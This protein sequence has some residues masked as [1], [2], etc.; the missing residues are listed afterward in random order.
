MVLRHSEP[1]ETGIM[2]SMGP[3]ATP[4]EHVVVSDPLD[5]VF[6]FEDPLSGPGLSDAP[7]RTPTAQHHPSDFV[8]LQQQHVTAGYRDGVTAAKAESVQAGFDEGFSLGAAIGVKAGELI[9][10]LEGVVR[11]LPG[12]LELS[13]LLADAKKELDIRSVFAPEYWAADGTWTYDVQAAEGDEVVFSDVAAAHPLI[14][15]WAEIV[16]AEMRKWSIDRAVLSIGD[17][18]R[19]G[20]AP[21]EKPSA[22]EVPVK[23]AEALAW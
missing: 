11:A 19:E 23:Q 5:D 20:A 4:A 8:R 18:E 7:I 22:G 1:R 14:R 16:D 2:A 10:L 12:S 3:A 17:E 15:K 13:A 21:V 6:G 9:G